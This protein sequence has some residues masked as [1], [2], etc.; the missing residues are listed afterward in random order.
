[1]SEEEYEVPEDLLYISTHE[2]IKQ[3]DGIVVL[4]VTDYAQKMLHEIVYVELPKKEAKVSKGESFMSVESIK[5]VS[6][7]YAPVS[8]KVVE[9]NGELESYPE[10]V[11]EAPYGEGWLVKIKAS[12][13]EKES[14]ELLGVKAYKKVIEEESR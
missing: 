7:I 13:W 12:A 8:G 11:N 5:A 2:W 14:G 9:V 4:G 3:E 6:D 1:M 10:K